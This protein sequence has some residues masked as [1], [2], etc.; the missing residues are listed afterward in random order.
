GFMFS[1]GCIQAMQCNRNTCPAGVTSH[2]PDLQ[3]GLVPEDKA[4]RVNHYHANLVNEVELIAHACGVSEPRLLRREHA[5]MVVEGGRSVPLSV[6]YPVVASTP[7]QP[8]A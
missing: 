6:L 8:G 3:R 1:L 7:H 4:E 2:D 5:A